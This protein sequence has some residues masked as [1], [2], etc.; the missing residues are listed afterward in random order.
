LIAFFVVGGMFYRTE[1]PSSTKWT[2]DP[3]PFFHEVKA[4][5][6]ACS[7]GTATGYYVRKVPVI[8][9]PLGT[10]VKSWTGQGYG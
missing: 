6:V 8:G 5:E 9:G 10:F 1:C 4:G 7:T 2:F 3:L